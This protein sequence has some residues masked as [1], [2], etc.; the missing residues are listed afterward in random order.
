MIDFEK[1]HL[2]I[3]DLKA[4]KLTFYCVHIGYIIC[5]IGILIFKEIK[6][7]EKRYKIILSFVFALIGIVFLLLS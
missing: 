6:F 4:K 1:Y 7:K 5:L 2:I 3:K